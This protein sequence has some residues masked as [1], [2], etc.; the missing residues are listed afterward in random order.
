M[1]SGERSTGPPPPRRAAATATATAATASATAA[2]AVQLTP[3]SVPRTVAAAP[4]ALRG[5]RPAPRRPGAF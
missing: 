4:A 5:R 1:P 3:T 2:A